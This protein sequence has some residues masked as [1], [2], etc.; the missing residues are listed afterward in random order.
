MV[1]CLS[2]GS[3]FM[4]LPYWSVWKIICV[5]VIQSLM[6]SCVGDVSIEQWRRE[7]KGILF[8]VS[9][10]AAPCGLWDLSFLTKD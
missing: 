6:G 10:V 7:S 2:E 5:K 1:L 4:E 9:L 3:S 8:S